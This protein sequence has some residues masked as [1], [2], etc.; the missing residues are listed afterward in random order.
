MIM[1]RSAAW[2]NRCN[3]YLLMELPSSTL[4]WEV[5]WRQLLWICFLPFNR[6]QFFFWVKPVGCERKTIWG[7]L[8]FRLLRLGAKVHQTITFLLRCPLY[9]HSPCRKPFRLQY[10]IM[11]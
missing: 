6:V 3:L 7:I 2:I 1:L 8:F 10:V 4:V 11:D 9:L 5:R